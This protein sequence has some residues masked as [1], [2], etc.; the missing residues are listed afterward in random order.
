M[1]VDNKVNKIGHG[2]KLQCSNSGRVAAAGGIPH[3]LVWDFWHS[4]GN[5]SIC[6][7]SV[8]PKKCCE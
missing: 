1:I 5:H 3:F 4:A 8:S 6:P 7:C 2:R